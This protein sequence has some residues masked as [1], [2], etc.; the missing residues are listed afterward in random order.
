MG[1]MCTAF[2]LLKA[3]S[4]GRAVE[5][6]ALS[7]ALGDAAAFLGGRLNMRSVTLAGHSYG[8]ATVAALTAADA[9]FSA[10]IALDPWWC[11]LV[12]PASLPGCECAVWQQKHAM[13][14]VGLLADATCHKLIVA[15]RQKT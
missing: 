7:G 1:E 8:G 11:A 10:G 3:L 4:E 13:R 15:R 14:E 9:R 12:P 2:D 5:G 6:L